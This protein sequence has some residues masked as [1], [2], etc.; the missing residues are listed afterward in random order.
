MFE[1]TRTLR[2]CPSG[3][4]GAP[5]DNAHAAWPPPRGLAGVLSLDLTIAGRPD[6]GTGV[7]LNVKDLD[8]AFAAAALPRF[9]AAAGAE[10]AGLLRG[11]AQA[12]APTLPF[13]LLRLRLSASASASTE[14]RPAD[15]SRVILRQ[16]FS[17]SAA[18]RLQADALSEEENRTLFGKCNRPSF[19]GHN[20]ELEV[21]AAA[22]IAPDGRSLE[23]AALDAA[24]RTRVIDTLD[25]RNLNTDVA[26]FA[27]RNP[28]VEHIAQTCWDLLAG[29]LPEGAELQEVVVWETD[30][31]SCAYRGG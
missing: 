9:R 26:A 3:D 23:P 14:L 1:L 22:A 28:T 31:T 16:R 13:P 8:A 11:V 19:H 25:H 2:F 29:G 17:F 30:R 21:A 27:T 15:M 10:P 24:V 18:H 7:L 20:Y 6:P 12:L 4:P 5:R